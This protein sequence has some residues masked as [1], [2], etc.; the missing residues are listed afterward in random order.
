MGIISAS[1][2][3]IEK[4][5]E[6]QTTKVFLFNKLASL[7]FLLAI[8]M[9]AIEMKSFE[10]SDLKNMCNGKE[11]GRLLVPA[12]LLF[13]SVLCKGAQMPF[14]YWLIDAVKANIFASIL[15]HAGTIVGVGI[16]FITKCYF[17][18]DCF[19]ILQKTMIGIGMFTA[20]WLACCALVHNNI[21]KVIACLT[22]SS[23]GIMY[24]SCG[25]GM[26]SL[27]LLYFVCHAFFKAMVFLSYAYLI[28]AAFGERNVLRLGGLKE[29]APRVSDVVWISFLAAVGFPFL[30]GFF[31]KIAFMD[32]AQTFGMTLIIVSN[33]AVNILATAALFRLI[34]LS[35]YG[36]A[37]ADDAT[38]SRVSNSN[39]FDVK[40]VWILIGCSIFGAFVAWSW[41]EYNVLHF[42]SSGTIRIRNVFDYFFENIKE[43]A[44]I[45]ASVLLVLCFAKAY[46][47]G[48]IKFRGKILNF[49]VLTFRR[50]KIHECVCNFVKYFTL[51]NM[52]IVNAMNNKFVYL[53]TDGLSTALCCA[54]KYM[55]RKYRSKLQA[56]VVWIIFGLFL[57][58]CFAMIH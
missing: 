46:N 36:K 10:F 58:G 27:A 19:P 31:A 39:S 50:N 54:T 45:A 25:M 22:A 26:Y 38:L 1:L 4:N 53:A 56:H 12:T 9:I 41:Y 51:R 11:C 23:A 18:F 24:T 42:G 37:K 43:V 7:L 17:L 13:V 40:P 6:Q 44:Q 16:I 52:K 35:M 30:P 8:V 32:S 3:G 15:I 29:Y 5:S 33:V 55:N 28:A 48:V 21:K 2:V 20:V 14:S 47:S 49:V 57:L 34:L